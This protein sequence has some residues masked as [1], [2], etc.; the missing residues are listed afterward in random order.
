MYK[1]SDAADLCRRQVVEVGARKRQPRGRSKIMDLITV[2]NVV[3]N[4]LQRWFIKV[5]CGA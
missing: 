2:I 5:H 1:C 4:N 3:G